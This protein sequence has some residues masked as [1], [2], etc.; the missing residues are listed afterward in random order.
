MCEGEIGEG[1]DEA[2]SIQC[3]TRS[4]AAIGSA[5]TASIGTSGRGAGDGA[6][7]VAT[8]PW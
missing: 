3:A 7:A 6:T 8:G 2:T 1:I 5:V 4:F